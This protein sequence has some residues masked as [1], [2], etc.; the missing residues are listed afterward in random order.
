M[1][2]CIMC[3]SSSICCLAL[4]L[5]NPPCFSLL[6][7]LYSVLVLEFVVL[8]HV[9]LWWGRRG[10]FKILDISFALSLFQADSASSYQY[11]N[12]P[13]KLI[14]QI[15]FFSP[16]M[17][18]YAELPKSKPISGRDFTWD[19]TPAPSFSVTGL[20]NGGDFNLQLLYQQDKNPTMA[21]YIMQKYF[22]VG[23]PRLS[24]S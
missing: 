7:S 3:L 12:N 17:P 19:R 23:W 24:P 13:I 9:C 16:T 2:L 10:T 22:V 6:L 11:W 21:R 20:E 15:K 4:I 5:W 14:N 8:V 18:L 1:F